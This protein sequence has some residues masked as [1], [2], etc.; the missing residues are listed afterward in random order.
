[1]TVRL[2]GAVCVILGCGGF[3]FMIAVNARREISALR[4]LISVM[5]FI[6]CELNY[7]RPPLAQLCRLTAAIANGCVKRLLLCI[8]E[9]LDQQ[10]A[11]SVD[12][13]ITAAIQHIP[14]LP[15][16]TAQRVIELGKSLGKFD[17]DGQIKCIRALNTENTRLL[18]ELT[19]DHITRIRSYKTLGLCAGAAMAILF[20]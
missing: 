5:D 6:E 17:L 4:Q 10:K 12:K 8:A 9:E 1:M 3:G 16:L 7:R 13:C 2:L 15:P 18:N 14:D 20:I 11:D 19:V